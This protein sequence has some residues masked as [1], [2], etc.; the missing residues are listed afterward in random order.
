MTTIAVDGLTK[1]FGDV[2]AVDNLT[3][4]LQAGTVTGFLGPNGAGKSTTLRMLLGLVRPTAGRA[5]FDGVAYAALARPAA[6]V[7]ALLDTNTFHPGRR[8]SDELA[9][10]AMAAGLPDSAVGVALE[11]VGLTNSARRRVGGFSQGMRQRLG[12]AAALLADPEIL[13]LDEPTNGLDPEGVHWLRCLLRELGDAGRT[14]LMSSHLL[15]EVAQT[16]DD[17]IV[18]SSGHLVTHRPLVEL[19][20]GQHSTVRVR[21]PQAD[22]LATALAERGVIAEAQPDGALLIADASPEIVGQAVA[23]SGVVVYEMSVTEP[24]LE[25][26]F[27]QLTAPT[28]GSP[29]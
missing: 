13:I 4:R 11:R 24:K 9:V 21:T 8:A 23:Q 29:S 28:A 3:F 18:I 20:A 5:T 16:V 27:F 12:L 25:D 10:R 17:V 1:R 19:S 14:V 2:T 15:A 7:G 22:V 26:S 6:T